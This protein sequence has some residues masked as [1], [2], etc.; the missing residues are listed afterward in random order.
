[1][2][3]LRAIADYLWAIWYTAWDLITEEE[4][5]ADSADCDIEDDL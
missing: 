5:I 3:F 2:N 1:M 4:E